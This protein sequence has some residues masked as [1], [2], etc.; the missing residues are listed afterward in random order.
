MGYDAVVGLA[1]LMEQR[2][3]LFLST[4]E[5]AAYVGI[6]I[7]LGAVRI[8]RNPAARQHKATY[9]FQSS[10]FPSSK[11]VRSSALT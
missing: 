2:D 10:G 5:K 11:R 6:N 8:R 3:D 9:I 4:R 7:D 1:W